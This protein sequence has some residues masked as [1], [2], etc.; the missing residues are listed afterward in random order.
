MRHVQDKHVRRQEAGEWRQ[1][2][3]RAE[4]D[5]WWGQGFLLGDANTLELDRGEFQNIPPSK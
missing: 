1:G 5:C 2:L 3:G 4:G